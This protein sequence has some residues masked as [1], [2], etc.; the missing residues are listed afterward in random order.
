MFSFLMGFSRED[1][2]H[3]NTENK[4]GIH[5]PV[6]FFY[7]PTLP[8][9]PQFSIASQVYLVSQPP[10]LISHHCSPVK[11]RVYRQS[12]KARA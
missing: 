5:L 2:V 9:G 8:W 3:S 6:S 12:P 10:N 1:H 7:Q 11:S 4:L